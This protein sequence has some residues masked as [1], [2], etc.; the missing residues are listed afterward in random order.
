MN[1]EEVLKKIRE[2]TATPEERAMFEQKTAE[3]NSLVA[4]KK[5]LDFDEALK[6][7]GDGSATDE[8]RAYVAEQLEEANAL[9]KAQ[10][11]SE[12]Q[13]APK[14][15][16]Q[17]PA[18]APYEDEDIEGEMFG[19]AYAR[20]VLEAEEVKAGIDFED[21]LEHVQQG[22]ATEQEKLYVKSQMAAA[23]AFFADD[24]RR[25]SAPVKEA[26]GEDVKKAKRSFKMHYV[27][28]P[29]CVLLV[30][31]IAIGAIL[32]GVFGYAAS[33]AKKNMTLT[34]D[35][36]KQFAIQ[37]VVAHQSELFSGLDANAFNASQL[38]VDDFDRQFCYNDRNLAASYYSYVVEVKGKMFNGIRTVEIE[39][40]LRINSATSGVDVIDRD[41]DD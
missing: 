7:V 31:V 13:N 38:Y 35:G 27:I 26:S 30:I 5:P 39:V 1:F 2:G 22:T 23:N 18:P 36:C 28:I 14:A 6:H 11:P 17:T 15:E 40:E 21:A 9:L 33:S 8:E 34:P 25:S 3:A 37:Y 32:G 20:P 12:G 41:I 10:A 16:A 24:S 29:V 4:G 19:Y